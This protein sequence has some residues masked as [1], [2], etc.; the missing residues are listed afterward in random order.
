M[1]WE[2]VFFALQREKPGLP[3]QTQYLSL[4]FLFEDE[5]ISTL[6]NVTTITTIFKF[7][8]TSDEHRSEERSKLIPSPDTQGR[9]QKADSSISLSQPLYENKFKPVTQETGEP[10][11]KGVIL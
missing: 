2:H 6:R 11:L 4:F 5:G 10:N 3:N 9:M 8:Q 7:Q 1:W